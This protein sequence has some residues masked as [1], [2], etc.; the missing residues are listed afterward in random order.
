MG[1]RPARC[2]RWLGPTAWAA[3]LQF[4]I[5]TEWSA[6][7]ATRPAALVTGAGV[8]LGRAIALDLAAH[9]WDVAIHYGRS[10]AEAQTA[11]AEA[12][13]AGADAEAF[14]QDLAQSDALAGLIARVVERFP[15]LSLLVNSASVYTAGLIAKTDAALLETQWRVN[16][17][18]P[19]LLTKAFAAHVARGNVVNIIDNKI[20]FNQNAYAAYL[21]SKKSLAD[22]TRMAALEFAPRIRVN[23]VAPGVILPAADRS[24]D[25][26][27]WR[28][29]AIPLARQG[30]PAHICAALRAL[31]ANEFVTGQIWT[32][33]G[34]ETIAHSGRNF[35]EYRQDRGAADDGQHK[36]CTAI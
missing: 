6:S 7:T 17:V 15:R 32:I 30:D 33:D 1:A 8:R 13:A 9:G 34:G 4:H 35:A 31:V 36:R 10:A 14:A 23:A 16:L 20:G 3:L 25:Y 21:L 26:V 19:F 29:Q 2:Q 11:V 24:A 27:A 28:L 5:V 18:A 22:F 12:R